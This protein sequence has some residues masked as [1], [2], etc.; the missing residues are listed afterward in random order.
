MIVKKHILP[1]I[2]FAQFSCTSLWFAGNAVMT[3][4]LEAFQL[5][6]T[7]LGTLTAAVQLGFITGT[8]LFALLTIADRFSPSKVFLASAVLGAGFNLLT[9]W[10]D[11]TLATLF[12][13]RFLTGLCLA[14]IYPVGMK[15]ASD[16]FQKGLGRSLGY[17]VGALVLGTAFPHLLKSLTQGA[18][19]WRFVL[20]LTSGLAMLGGLLLYLLVPNGPFRSPSAKFDPKALIRV[21]ENKPFRRAAVGYFGH[22]WE[23]YTFWAFIPLMLFS[24]QQQQ[25]IQLDIPFVSFLVIGLGGIACVLGGYLSEKLGISYTALGALAF[26]GVCCLLYPFIFQLGI[27]VLF[28][29]FLIFWG[30]MVILDSPLFSTLVAQNAPV[31]YKG[32][33][34]TIVTCMGFALTIGS[35]QLMTYLFELWGERAFWVLALGPIVG[36]VSNRKTTS[37]E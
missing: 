19:P 24:Y 6:A 36:L 13:F 20:L 16:Y 23:L 30:L 5:E 4:L 25:Q 27:T 9:I 2:V 21:F 15:I 12:G 14:G 26:S 11:N 28:I 18:L 35:I 32:T 1:T 3:D 22:M 8:L 7:A 34:L 29:A 33:A 31:A 17:L 37:K 10:G